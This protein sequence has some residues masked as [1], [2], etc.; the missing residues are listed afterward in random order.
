MLESVQDLTRGTQLKNPKIKAAVREAGTFSEETPEIKTT[1]RIERLFA[2]SS[3]F[4]AVT[5]LIAQDDFSVRNEPIPK[6][7]EMFPA[8][9]RMQFV[10]LFYPYSKDGPLYLD[11]PMDPLQ[12]A[13]CERKLV[14]MRAKGMRYTYIKPGEAEWEGRM[15]LDGQDPDRIKDDQSKLRNQGANA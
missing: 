6:G 3:R 5:D 14:A 15:R 11:M 4:S 8:E 2:K 9:W 10:D 13:L 1:K 7:K 12:I